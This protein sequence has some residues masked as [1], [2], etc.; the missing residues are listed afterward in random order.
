MKLNWKCVERVCM[1]EELLAQIVRLAQDEDVP[2]EQ[3]IT[4]LLEEALETRRQDE[5]T[6]G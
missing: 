3:M 4:T 2:R 6:Q 5:L 1:P